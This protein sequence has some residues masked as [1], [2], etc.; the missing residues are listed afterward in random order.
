[1]LGPKV[2]VRSKAITRQ[3]FPGGILGDSRLSAR[4]TARPAIVDVEVESDGPLARWLRP[5]KHLGAVAEGI[6][7]TLGVPELHKT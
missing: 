1:M 4:G 3:E 2:P 5:G 7:F 6:T